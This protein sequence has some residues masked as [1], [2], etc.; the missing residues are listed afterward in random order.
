MTLLLGG[1]FSLMAQND[2]YITVWNTETGAPGSKEINLNIIGS[3]LT[4]DW[5]EV[6]NATNNHGTITNATGPLLMDFPAAGV[7]KVSVHP[8]GLTGLR[9]T[10]SANGVKLM[11]VTQW[12]DAAFTSLN[13]AFIDCSNM[14]VTATDAPVL[15]NINAFGLSSMF[16]NAS[17]FTGQHTP[18]EDWQTSAITDMNSM[19][20][21]ATL[22]NGK[23]GGWDVHSV[24]NMT[25]MFS[26]A[27][28]FDQN[29]NSWDVSNVT[30]MTNMFNRA[31]TFNQPL[32]NWAHKLGKVTYMTGMFR[33]T[34]NFNQDISSWDVSNVSAFTEMFKLAQA[35]NQPLNTWGDDLE[36]A[37]YMQ[38]IFEGAQ[39]FNQPL[40]SWNVSNISNF[41]KMFFN[42]TAFNQSLANWTF[43]PAAFLSQMLYGAGLS[44]SNLSATLHGWASN[45]N[46]PDNMQL[47]D[48][49]GSY[50]P[51]GRA[52]YIKLDVDK[53]WDMSGGTYDE[54][55]DESSLPVHFGP[56]TATLKNNE[57]LV[58][59]TTLS[60]T[61]NSH[62][63]IQVSRNGTDFTTIATVKSKAPNGTT[64]QVTD[65]EQ[66]IQLPAA[67]LSA[68]TITF[69]LFSFGIKKRKNLYL[70]T[71]IVLFACA[72]F[73]CSRQDIA[74]IET[75]QKLFVRIVQV[76]IDGTKSFSKT[77]QVVDGR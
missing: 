1:S 21:G 46:T 58:N 19:F 72:L 55:C 68:L 77:V 28:A 7:Y 74:A 76:D 25:S 10:G 12:G 62:F 38:S 67:V 18:M 4:I 11:T 8:T 50:G 15:T 56:V 64:D 53:G 29:I 66:P 24:T 33:N 30:D 13:R 5:E 35:F 43:K 59:W 44:C 27:S 31:H 51:L 3:N 36:N 60:E 42:A 39:A 37:L 26:W 40:S 61:N 69:V 48:V 23:I 6:G 41:N 71:S 70:L 2:P 17:S 16:S 34:E 75:N 22:F 9:N 49:P 45:P 52:A 63:N 20:S 65:Y 73:A 32:N 47:L 54:N 14:E 57:L